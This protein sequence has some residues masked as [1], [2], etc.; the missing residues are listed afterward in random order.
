MRM[1]LQDVIKEYDHVASVYDHRWNNYLNKTL[2]RAIGYCPLVGGEDILDVACGTG[3]LEKRLIARYSKIQITGCDISSAMLEVAKR[4]IGENNRIAFIEC[5]ADKI[6]IKDESKDIVICCNSFHFFKYP[7]I[8]LSEWCRIL[9]HNGMVFILD[10]CRNFWPCK[11]LEFSKKR[12]DR[13]HHHIYTLHE[14]SSTLN[15]CNFEEVRS[16]L[17]KAGWMWGMM[18]I[19]GKKE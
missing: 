18:A 17:F 14:L 4:K 11:V 8:V 10:W 7:E 19:L 2:D 5:P 16:W 9:R 12:I 3:E 13:A 6:P 1:I 15:R